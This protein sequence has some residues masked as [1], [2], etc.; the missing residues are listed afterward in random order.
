MAKISTD[1]EQLGGYVGDVGN[2]ECHPKA[3]GSPYRNVVEN[4]IQEE[5][6]PNCG[7]LFATK[8]ILAHQTTSVGL[9]YRTRVHE[10]IVTGA[11]T[12]V[13][14]VRGLCSLG[15]CRDMVLSL[16]TVNIRLGGLGLE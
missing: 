13:D 8:L 2:H 3:S 16:A 14:I 5:N 6:G 10:G 11:R 12:H 7:E 15:G 9:G 4:G 1:S